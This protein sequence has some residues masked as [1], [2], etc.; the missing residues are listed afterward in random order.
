[1]AEP[2]RSAEDEL[3]YRALRSI[4]RI[5]RQVS[6]HSRALSQQSGL[7]VPQLLCMRAIADLPA[8]SVTVAAVA[9][10]V[11]LS[12]STVSTIA[13]RLVRAGLVDR[14]RSE[15]DRRRVELS[16]TEE[17]ARRLEAMPRPLQDRF[18]ARL[19]ALDAAE[20][21]RVLSTLEQVVGLMEAEALDAAPMLAPGS[22][23]DGA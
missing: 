5:I 1:M 11:D 13:E 20:Q 9:E 7:T 3:G 10:T 2:P 23:V 6:T 8:G 12:R 18:L 22:D 17:G 15:R 4:R 21:E 19:A 14:V 16:L